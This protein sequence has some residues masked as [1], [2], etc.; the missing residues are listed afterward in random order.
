MIFRYQ[1]IYA[2]HLDLS[3]FF[4]CILCHHEKITA[5]DLIL[6]LYHFQRNRSPD[7]S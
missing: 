4:I 5:V 7:I 3:P 2:E 6:V 1:I